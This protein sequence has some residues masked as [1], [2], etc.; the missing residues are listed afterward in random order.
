MNTKKPDCGSLS[1]TICSAPSPSWFS[2]QGTPSCSKWFKTEIEILAW[3]YV[4]G[5]ARDGDAWHEMD[6]QR[7]YDLLTKDEQRYVRPYLPDEGGCYAD[8]W[9]MIGKQLK[10]ADG[11]FE[12]GGLAWTRHR[13]ALQNAAIRHAAPDSSQLKP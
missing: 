10:D 6:D 7:C 12:V 5:M 8:W 1:V 4:T 9:A 2:N 11:A 13:W 3:A